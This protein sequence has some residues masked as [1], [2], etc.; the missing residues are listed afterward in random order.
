MVFVIWIVCYNSMS[1]HF[2]VH[3]WFDVKLFELINNVSK[4]NVSVIW[5][6]QIFWYAILH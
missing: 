1:E 4:E 6:L 2:D 5:I 3:V